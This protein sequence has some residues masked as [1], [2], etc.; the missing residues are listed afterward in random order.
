MLLRT[1]DQCHKLCQKQINK[2]L[3]AGLLLLAGHAAAETPSKPNI[4]LLC[5][6][7]LGWTDVSTNA[8]NMGNSS[9]YYET[10]NI[11]RLA[12]MGM[13]FNSA[14]SQPNS[15]PTRAS[16][17]LGQYA[18]KTD[19]YCVGN[20]NNK[21]NSLI[22][23]PDQ[24][25]VIRKV[26]T[27][28]A[29]TLKTEGYT[30]AHFGKTHAMGDRN[31]LDTAHGYDLNMRVWH[32]NTYHAKEENGHWSF[33]KPTYD[34]YAIPYTQAYIDKHLKPYQNDSDVDSLVGTAK[35]LTDAMG[36][37]GIDYIANHANGSEPFYMQMAF[38]A[39]HVP[40]IS[41]TDLK[42]KY[43][44]KSSAGSLHTNADYAGFVEGLDIAIGRIMDALYDPN[45][46]GNQS[47]SIADNTLVMLYSDNGGY[48]G[49]TVNTPLRSTK[50]TMYEGGLRVPLIASMP[51]TI[52]SGAISDEAV[53]A[54]DIYSTFAD[55][56]GADLPDPTV[57]EVDG[58][59]FA[60]ILKGQ[61][62][63]LDRDSLYWHMPGYW[64]NYMKHP[65]SVINKRFGDKRY[66][67]HYN[68]ETEGYELYDLSNDIGETNNLLAG[69][70]TKQNF[71]IAANM[72]KDLRNWLQESGAKQG[73]VRSTGRA[74][75][76]LYQTV[77]F[78]MKMT[79]P[80]TLNTSNATFTNMDVAMSIEAVGSNAALAVTSEGIGILSDA[81]NLQSSSQRLRINGTDESINFWFDHDVVLS[82]IVVG[83]ENTGFNDD[84]VSLTFVAGDNPF[85]SLEGYDSD[86]FTQNSN[87]ITFDVP[88]FG[89]DDY[90]INFG[91][92]ERDEILIKAGT[93]LALSTPNGSVAGGITLKD[94]S[95]ALP[96]DSIALPE[97]TAL[98][99]LAGMGVPMLTRR[100]R[101]RA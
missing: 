43:E 29:E 15:A 95:V 83:L 42:A 97:P 33:D 39:V 49:G 5:A 68:Y 38:Q 4:V 23:A 44:A 71:D 69:D 62:S 73:T 25:T 12:D 85:D 93:I 65:T 21:Q 32:G 60:G 80:V 64:Q 2:T 31:Q 9:T 99:M 63:S 55:F 79:T 7:D 48:E 47:D 1:L 45:G 59:S 10:P 20:I 19:L 100:S 89:S 67:L 56:A 13:S 16:L 53:H 17:I 76:A 51:G 78:S 61:E 74:V 98:M 101:K 50:H 84:L 52:A 91:G 87:S 90:T 27:T 11:A 54:I 81:E 77:A 36:D 34:A 40:I 88:G 41:R 26:T 37:A 75:E 46:D 28:V 14:Y 22:V 92:L 8:T 82:S 58:E 72:G 3:Y 96:L 6:D 94:I 18:P 35:H 30:T 70:F 24:R 57:H 86:Y 66:K